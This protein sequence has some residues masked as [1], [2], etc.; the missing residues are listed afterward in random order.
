[1]SFTIENEKQNR[2]LFLDVQITGA[3]KKITTS[4]YNEPTFRGIYAHFFLAFYHLLSLVLPTLYFWI[5]SSCTKCHIELLFLKQIFVKI[6]TLKIINVSKDLV[7]KT[8]LTVEKKPLVLPNY[9]P[10]SLQ[11]M[12]RLRNSSRKHL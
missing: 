12:A 4:V 5:C 1:M 8:T 2:M 10:I 9:S 7:K 3:D 6:T 11:T